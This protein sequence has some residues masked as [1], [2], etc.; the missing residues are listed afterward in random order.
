MK[1]TLVIQV[2][3]VYIKYAVLLKDFNLHQKIFYDIVF[4]CVRLIQYYKN[5]YLTN[6]IVSGIYK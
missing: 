2:W 4:K 3:L 5:G 6:F 1:L